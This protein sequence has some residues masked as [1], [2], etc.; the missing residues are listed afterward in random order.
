MDRR[1]F[2]R[3]AAL[4][5]LCITIS[6]SLIESL[7]ISSAKA[8]ALP[9]N[10]AGCREIPIRLEDTPDLKKIGG[11]YHLEIDELEKNL[12]VVRIEEDKFVTVNIKCTHKGCDVTYKGPVVEKDDEKDKEDD[13]NGKLKKEK[14]DSQ[15]MFFCPCHSSTFDLAGNPT[16]GPA[17]KPLGNYE[18]TYKDGEVTIKI[19]AEGETAPAP[20]TPADSTKK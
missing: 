5:G 10:A 15:P 19:P 3:N 7:G 16:G 1:E 9:L 2:I 6:S 13:G 11:A 18:T 8:F 4:S 14:K 12:L 17:K 20:K